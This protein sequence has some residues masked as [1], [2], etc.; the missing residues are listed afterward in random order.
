MSATSCTCT[1]GPSG[2]GFIDKY[3]KPA[4]TIGI[5][6]QSLK[7]GGVENFMQVPLA[8]A[9][10]EG[11]LW[12]KDETLRISVL[13]NIKEYSSERDSAVTETIDEIDLILKD[14][15]KVISFT[16]LGAPYKLKAYVDSLRCGRNG[17]YGISECNQLLGRRRTNTD[18]IGL[19]PIQRGTISSTMVDGTSST[20][21]KMMVTFQIDERYNDAEFVYADS[22]EITADLDETEAMI[23][24]DA[25][26]VV[27]TATK[28]TVTMKWAASGRVSANGLEPLENFDASSYFYLYNNNT[29]AAITLTSV[30]ETTAGV[31]E[32]TWA[33]GTTA[34][35]DMTL[36]AGALAPF[37]FADITGLTAV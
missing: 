4:R 31:Y 10:W 15:K 21:G 9:N 5:G 35:D 34:A 26:A 12:N 17:F 24:A 11:S 8:Q 16:I 3:G 23:Q 27:S 7:S 20:F 18:E 37:N 1:S 2:F 13:N 36:S 25:T 22:S 28:V 29:L 33:T 30:T 32:L 19:I 14:G 6:F